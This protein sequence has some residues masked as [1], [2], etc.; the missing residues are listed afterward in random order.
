MNIHKKRR[1]AAK[2]GSAALQKNETMELSKYGNLICAKFRHYVSRTS[3]PHLCAHRIL[4]D[5]NTEK[6]PRRIAGKAAVTAAKGYSDGE[7]IK[8]KRPK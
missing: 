3:E 4:F 8:E 6:R 5:P 2:S 7:N 1:D